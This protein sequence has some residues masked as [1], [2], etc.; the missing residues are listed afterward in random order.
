MKFGRY[1]AIRQRS[2]VTSAG[3]C[4]VDEYY[5]IS[6][7]HGGFYYVADLCIS[8]EIINV[9]GSHSEAETRVCFGR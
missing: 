6:I 3:H 4:S 8:C 2:Q 5:R 1:S 9:H 7:P